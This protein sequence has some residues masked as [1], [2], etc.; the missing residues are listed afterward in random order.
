MNKVPS[1]WG[2]FFTSRRILVMLLQSMPATAR[3]ALDALRV[4]FSDPQKAEPYGE[5]AV[6]D[7]TRVGRASW[8]SR[9]D[10]KL[11]SYAISVRCFPPPCVYF[12]TS[13]RRTSTAPLLSRGWPC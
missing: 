8:I 5:R 9:E 12:C 10:T 11:E 13:P 4:S 7:A 6:L 2:T 1:T 3:P